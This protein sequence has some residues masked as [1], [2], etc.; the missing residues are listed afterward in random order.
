MGGSGRA[1][2]QPPAPSPLAKPR[3]AALT[4]C[5]ITLWPLGPQGLQARQVAI[6]P[7]TPQPVGCACGL[8]AF[9]HH[10]LVRVLSPPLLCLAIAIAV[11][12]AV[13]V[14]VALT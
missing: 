3:L 1:L 2:K 12:V 8:C 13:A 7:Q 6:G 9:R 10:V 11:A 5:L 14:A 4:M